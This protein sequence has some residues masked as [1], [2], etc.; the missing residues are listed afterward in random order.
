MAAWRSF[1]GM[2]LQEVADL[3][4]VTKQMISYVEHGENDIS[5]QKLARIVIKAFRTDM[6]TFFGPFPRKEAA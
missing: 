4:E 3:S 6:P 2:T 1:R 5:V